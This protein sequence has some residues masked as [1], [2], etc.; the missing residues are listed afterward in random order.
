MIGLKLL[1]QPQH[2]PGKAPP[3]LHLTDGRLR[4]VQVLRH[5]ALAPAEMLAKGGEAVHAANNKKLTA[6]VNKHLIEEIGMLTGMSDQ[7]IRLRQARERAGYKTA[8]AA[9]AAM[10]IQAGTYRHHE[11][12]TAGLSRMGERY[13][14]FFRVNYAWLMTGRGP[15]NLREGQVSVALPM[16]GYVAAGATVVAPD[17]SEPLD[18]MPL[19][20]PEDCGVLVVRGQSG[21]PRFL[22][23][24]RILFELRPTP[25]DRLLGHYAVVQDKNGTRMLKILRRGSRPD[26]F[27]LES[28]NAEPL[29]DVELIGAWRYRGCLPAE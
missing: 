12:G 13:A 10:G 18:E 15:M 26:R 22:E 16:Y 14:S 24:E 20:S 2:R 11:N 19:P 7:H 23:G 3:R 27:T 21:Y 1:H 28:H 4:D 5:S 6:A 8:A 17:D 9:A 25:P 29:R